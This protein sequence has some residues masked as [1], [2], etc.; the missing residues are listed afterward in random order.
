[1]TKNYPGLATPQRY[2]L[3]YDN[4]DQLL[5]APLK[6]A[7]NNALVRQYIYGYDP[8]SNRTSEQMGNSTTTSTPNNVN[9]ITSQSGAINRTLS[10]DANGGLTSDGGT[11]S[12]E[13]DGANRLVAV[14]YTGTTQRTEFSYDGLNRCVTL[15]E[16]TGNTINSTRKFV[17]CGTE[18]CEFRNASGGVQ[19]QLYPQGQYQSGSAYFYARDHLGS[20]R[21]MTNASGTVVARYDYDPWGRLTTVIGT[22]KPDFTF[23]GLYAHAKSG[24]DMAVYRFYDPDLGRW[25][26]RDRIGETG[27]LN[28]YRYVANDPVNL[29][30]PDGLTPQGALIGAGIGTWVGGTIGGA[31]GGTIGVVGG[32]AGGTLVAPGVGTVGGA[33][34]GG[35][36][37]GTEG[38]VGGAV[39]GG[40]FGAWAGDVI[41]DLWAQSK[42][43]PQG[44]WPGDRGAEEWGRRNGVDPR[45][46]RGRFHGIKQRCPGSKPRDKFGVN[47]DTG[48]V[49]D[50]EGEDAG[51]LG[52]VKPK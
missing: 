17:W 26:S 40:G 5:S 25:L 46:A 7:T 43:L 45:Q 51:N 2:D 6:K 18:R 4:A 15:V 37:L 31:I 44:Y 47:P 50:T 21:E 20:V 42:G 39:I 19:L 8:A 11:R 38:T 29:Y 49:I 9:E 13:W 33:V 16:K 52:D 30:D 48:D 28:L 34:V 27:G 36:T 41:S 32:G 35:A 23:T 12:F 3:G 14:N 24:L 22:N 1:L 10:Y